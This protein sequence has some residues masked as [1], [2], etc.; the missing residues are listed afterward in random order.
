MLTQGGAMTKFLVAG[1]AGY[2]GTALVTEL[3]AAGHCATVFDRFSLGEA[4]FAHVADDPRLRLVHGDVRTVEASVVRGHDVVIDLAGP[5][6]GADG[7]PRPARSVCPTPTARC[8]PCPLGLPT[9]AVRK[10]RRVLR[11]GTFAGSQ[12]VVP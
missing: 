9:L 12:E 8:K 10:G 3:L 2:V 6:G 4:S 5:A 7:L 1:G 11:Q